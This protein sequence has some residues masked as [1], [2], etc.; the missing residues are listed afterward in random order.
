MK[1]ILL[2]LFAVLKAFLIRM[3]SKWLIYYSNS[4]LFAIQLQYR[5]QIWSLL[6]I[7]A[8]FKF[9]E[10]ASVYYTFNLVYTRTT[11]HNSALCH[12]RVFCCLRSIYQLHFIM[13][14]TTFY[15]RCSTLLTDSKTLRLDGF[16]GTSEILL[17]LFIWQLPFHVWCA[18]FLE[19][20]SLGRSYLLLTQLTSAG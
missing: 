13:L 9:L 19:V 7:Y 17:D 20:W 12:R 1:Y 11:P 18:E 6:N 10:L 2:W 14:T 8:E 4:Y 3:P 5:N 15:C 16:S